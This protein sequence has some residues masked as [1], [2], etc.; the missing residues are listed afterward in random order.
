MT[1]SDVARANGH[2]T[3]ADWLDGLR[4]GLE[5]TL[6]GEEGEGEGETSQIYYSCL[7]STILGDDESTL[8]GNEEEEEE[9]VEEIPSRILFLD[10]GELRRRLVELNFQ[11]GPIGPDTEM[12]YKRHLARLEASGGQRKKDEPKRTHTY[13]M[14]AC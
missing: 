3:C 13:P 14:F 11:P 6:V 2:V 12:L 10:P 7:D 1:A 8:L 9:E 5:V 4:K